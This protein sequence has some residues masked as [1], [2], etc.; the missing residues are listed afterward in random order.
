M[1]QQPTSLA[2]IDAFFAA[3]PSPAPPQTIIQTEPKPAPK[4]NITPMFDVTAQTLPKQN[5]TCAYPE[6]CKQEPRYNHTFVF[7]GQNY[8]DVQLHAFPGTKEGAPI[9]YVW[10]SRDKP[11]HLFSIPVLDAKLAE[12]KTRFAAKKALKTTDPL[13]SPTAGKPVASKPAASKPVVS[14]PAEEWDGKPPTGQSDDDICRWKEECAYVKKSDGHIMSKTS[15]GL[16]Y[17]KRVYTNRSTGVPIYMSV[18]CNNPTIK[19]SKHTEIAAG[20]AG[21]PAGKPASKR[22]EKRPASTVDKARPAAKSAAPASEGTD[23]VSLL[24]LKLAKY[25]TAYAAARAGGEDDVEILRIQTDRIKSTDRALKVAKFQAALADLLTI[26]DM[27]GLEMNE[28]VNPA[29]E[30]FGVKTAADVE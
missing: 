26:P 24:A 13:T 23:A 8:G 2:A 12:V 11:N 29:F 9:S 28:L 5:L 17:H 14:K 20:P 16:T 10:C 7:D 6:T 19:S 1:D 30:K 27:T 21:K 3:N 4:Y 15:D 25:K 18:W 22:N